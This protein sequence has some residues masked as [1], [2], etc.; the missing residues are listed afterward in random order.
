[1]LVFFSHVPAG[2]GLGGTRPQKAGA[3]GCGGELGGE[4]NVE[5]EKRRRGRQRFGNSNPAPRNSQQ[6][7]DVTKDMDRPQ[8]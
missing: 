4:V 7:D 5:E 3:A 1:M 2:L 8:A 6:T